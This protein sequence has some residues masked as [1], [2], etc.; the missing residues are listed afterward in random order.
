MTAEERAE[1]RR[2]HVRQNVR[3]YRERN[4][5]RNS[6]QTTTTTTTSRANSETSKHDSQSSSKS[7]SPRLESPSELS[8]TSTTTVE[9]PATEPA[10]AAADEQKQSNGAPHTPVSS[11]SSSSIVTL[12][13]IREEEQEQTHHIRPPSPLITDFDRHSELAPI[14][15]SFGTLQAVVEDLEIFA[16]I[17]PWRLA[18]QTL[19]SDDRLVDLGLLSAGYRLLGKLRQDPRNTAYAWIPYHRTLQQLQRRLDEEVPLD[20][21]FCVLTATASMTLFDVSGEVL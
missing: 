19:S 13:R 4:K 17:W 20:Q 18:A 11:H 10:A 2:E 8:R 7:Q 14:D 16:P 1:A 5:A 21:A 15:I 6:N 9:R 3:A 12:A